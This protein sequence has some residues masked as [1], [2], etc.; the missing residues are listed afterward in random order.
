MVTAHSPATLKTLINYDL[1]PGQRLSEDD[2]MN[3][4]EKVTGVV[5]RQGSN[6]PESQA[7]LFDKIIMEGP[8]PIVNYLIRFAVEMGRIKAKESDTIYMARLRDPKAI[9]L[10]HLP[11]ILRSN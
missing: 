3:F 5:N 1:P 7:L 4:Q 2:I 10:G 11:S 6:S 9:R 8:A